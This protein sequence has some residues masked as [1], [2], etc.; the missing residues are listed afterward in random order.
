MASSNRQT[1]FA[2]LA[3]ERRV[4]E[5]RALKQE[6]KEQKKQDKLAGLSGEPLEPEA[7]VDET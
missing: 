7:A 2:K 5:K 6:K 3:R 4:Q 1:T